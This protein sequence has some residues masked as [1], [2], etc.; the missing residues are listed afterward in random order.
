MDGSYSGKRSRS[1]LDSDPSERNVDN[2]RRNPGGE[3][4]AMPGID[5]TV[6][7]ILCPGNKIGSVI[8]K[9]GSIIKQLRQDTHA[10]IKVADAIP[11]VDE[12]VII[13]FSPPKDRRKDKGDDDDD[14]LKENMKPLCPAQDALFRV[15]A[16]IVEDD[17]GASDD[18]DE[19]GKGKQV[20]VRLLVPNNQ[21]GCLLGRGGK[22]IEKMR[23]DTGAQ[24]KILPKE[25]LPACA[26]PADELV[27][28]VGSPP[29]V[30]K[31]LYEV[32]ARLH[33]NPPRE[34]LPLNNP[35]PAFGQNPFVPS[36][37]HLFSSANMLPQGLPPV[38]IV[39]P[40]GGY[41]SELGAAWPVSVARRN[42]NATQEDFT[43]QMLCPNERIGG[44]IGKGGSTIN[45]IRQETGANIKVIDQVSDCDER[46][47]LVSSKEYADDRVSPTLEAVLQ[48]QPR[49]C[50]K[51][52]EE[53]KEGVITTRFLVPSNHI[54][55][56][57]GKGGSI[58]SEMRKRTRANI[59]IMSK[60]N[61]PKCASENDELVQIIGDFE[62]A[63]DVLVEIATRL[64]SNVFKDKDGGA[65]ASSVLPG[66]LSFLGMP[67]SVPSSGFGGRQDLG[68][69]SG[70][71]SLSGLDLQGT[72]GGR[73]STGSYGSL[74]S[75]QNGGASGYGPISGYSTGRAAAG[76]LSLGMTRNSSGTNVEVTIPNKS[77]G[78]ILGRG[79]SNIAQIREISGA[80]VKLHD[81]KP[82]GTDRIVEISG[83][84]EQ[85]HA[86]QSLLQAFAMSGQNSRA[87]RAY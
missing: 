36:A 66:S 47:I 86:A 84:P 83:T 2:K 18:E 75:L 41:R 38:G 15:H 27:Q 51:S 80:K 10:K 4:E 19:D 12:R 1:H 30:K 14:Y 29:V 78:S 55:C 63:R 39:P 35:V 54:G 40:I 67:G 48:L 13:I 6:Y 42:Y 16:R 61:L 73:L 69:P 43:F 28:I 58:I 8:G 50:D 76:G 5:D 32:S 9:G 74:G 62:V 68:S 33:E 31:A 24:I 26:M 34:R 22:V 77:V 71:Y 20:T 87:A 85:T 79:G 17:R 44:V 21:I 3:R 81:A 37:G 56:L 72:A 70:M 52:K 59:R 11:G 64:R 25:Q 45:Q 53:G 65:N 49:T 60:D 23:S 46:V 57:L 82:G 7:R